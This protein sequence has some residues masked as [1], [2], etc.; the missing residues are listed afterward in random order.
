MSKDG[1]AHVKDANWKEAILNLRNDPTASAEMAGEL[2]KQ[3][4]ATLQENVGGKIG[5]TELYLAHFLGAGGASTFLNGMQENPKQSAASLLPEAAS[6]NQSVFYNKDGTARSLKQIYQ[7][8]AEKFDSTSSMSLVASTSPSSQSSTSAST[9]VAL[10]TPVAAATHSSASM[11]IASAASTVPFYN[12]STSFSG[13]SSAVAKASTAL[14][15]AKSQGSS[16]FATMML[17]QMNQDST[18]AL[19]SSAD[20]RDKKTAIDLIS[21][22]GALG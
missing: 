17:A 13:M 9:Q 15:D 6:A 10:A 7:H 18:S 19:Q 4:Q 8:F 22:A 3:N 20:N 21:A 14:N 1:S 11:T 16:L 5:G 2:D 12:S